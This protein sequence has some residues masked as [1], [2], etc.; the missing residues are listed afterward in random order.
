MPAWKNKIALV[1]VSFCG[2]FEMM[3]KIYLVTHN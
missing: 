1:V 3:S 2:L